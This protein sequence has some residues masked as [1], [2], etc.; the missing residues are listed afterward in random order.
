MAVNLPEKKCR[1]GGKNFTSSKKRSLLPIAEK[2]REVFKCKRT[3]AISSGQKLKAR[4]EIHQIFNKRRVSP[5]H[6]PA[7]KL[8]L[9][10]DN[11]KRQTR[12]KLSTLRQKTFKIGDR[13][14]AVKKN[15]FCRHVK[16]VNGPTSDPNGNQFDDDGISMCTNEVTGSFGED[17]EDAERTEGTDAFSVFLDEN[18]EGLEEIE[19]L[20]N[21]IDSDEDWCEWNSIMLMT[22]KSHALSVHVDGASTSALPSPPA[23]S[24]TAAIGSTTATIS[25]KL[26]KQNF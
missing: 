17:A 18:V 4:E 12:K 3:D 19:T 9:L 13:R 22:Q 24:T 6:R 25:E 16:E 10:W 21:H 23:C 8:K 11:I 5:E 2:Y 20:G 14:N 1:K 7:S 15:F 26:H